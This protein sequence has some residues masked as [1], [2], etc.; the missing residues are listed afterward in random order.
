MARKLHRPHYQS[1]GYGQQKYILPLPRSET[2]SF[3]P[4]KHIFKNI[5][6][7]EM[8]YVSELYCRTVKIYWN[9]YLVLVFKILSLT[10]RLI[11][12]LFLTNIYEN[13]QIIMLSKQCWKK[14]STINKDFVFINSEHKLQK[15]T[16]VIDGN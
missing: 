1:G 9:I 10:N 6:N 14:G 5:N 7:T 2:G 13:R 8:Q 4:Y 11:I 3:R 12:L 15:S 16:S